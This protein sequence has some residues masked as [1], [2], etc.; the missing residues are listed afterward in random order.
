MKQ[1][2]FFIHV[3]QCFL[4]ISIILF[5]N[6][7]RRTVSM[8]QNY[9]NRSAFVAPTHASYS[10]IF[11]RLY[12]AETEVD[13][14]EFVVVA[15]NVFPFSSSLQRSQMV[16][17]LKTLAIQH[18]AH[19]RYVT[20][21]NDTVFT[22]Q[23]AADLET[24]PPYYEASLRRNRDMR[25]YSEDALRFLQQPY[26]DSIVSPNA[27]SDYSIAY[28]TGALIR[29]TQL[30]IALSGDGQTDSDMLREAMNN[31]NL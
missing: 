8:H 20:A 13:Y 29:V 3:H 1:N 26:Q 30:Y 27:I 31:M 12:L 2:S 11:D 19:V 10:S 15:R 4:L 7:M 23:S 17:H 21:T 5:S 24:T 6:A 9:I 14:T 16:T 28:V 18:A 25:T 22:P